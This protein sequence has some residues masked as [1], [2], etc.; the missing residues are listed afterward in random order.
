LSKDSRAAEISDEQDEFIAYGGDD[1]ADFQQQNKN[2][3]VV[4][5]LFSGSTT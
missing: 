1:A 4:D 3:V 2:M 5:K